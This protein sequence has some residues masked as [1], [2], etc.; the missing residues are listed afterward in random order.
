[1]RSGGSASFIL[2][3][4]RSAQHRVGARTGLRIPLDLQSKLLR[5]LHR[6][7]MDMQ[8]ATIERALAR[9]NGQMYGKDGAAAL[10]GMKPTTRWSRLSSLGIST[11]RP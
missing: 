4:R 8:Y 9:C 7:I 10:L 5:V 2:P 11:E 6:E 1:V 3:S